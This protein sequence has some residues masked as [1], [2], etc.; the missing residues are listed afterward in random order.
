MIN[1]FF[2]NF[3]LG[4]A[5]LLCS[6]CITKALWGDKVYEERVSQLLMGGDNRYV[7]LVG[8]SY[9]YVLIDDFGT[10]KQVMSLKQ[11]GVLTMSQEDTYLK[12]DDNNDV[13]G[14][15]VFKGPFSV[16]PQEDMY[17]LQSMG[18]KPDKD[19]EIEVKIQ[20]SGRRYVAKYLGQ[21]NTSAANVNYVI[22]VYYSDSS[23]IKGIGKAA[24]TP[25]AVSLDA[26]LLIGKV[27]VSPLVM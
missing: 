14:L 9:H 17:M 20:L 19:D 21:Q 25:I 15:L 23:L 24:V 7:V 12:L 6:G 26:V 22:Q 16:L 3:I 8:E 5:L 1:K 11:K 13:K 27:I 2:I 18:F 10:L 4:S